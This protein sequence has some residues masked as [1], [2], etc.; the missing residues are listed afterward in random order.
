MSQGGGMSEGEKPVDPNAISTSESGLFQPNGRG[1]GEP[2]PDVQ[3]GGFRGKCI[4][5]Y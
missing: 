1:N 3:G 4:H 5:Q 2:V